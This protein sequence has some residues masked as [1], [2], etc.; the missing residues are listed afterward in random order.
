MTLVIKM[1][2]LRSLITTCTYPQYEAELT[3]KSLI[4]AHLNVLALGLWDIV[5]LLLR[6]CPALLPGVIHGG[7]ALGVLSPA[8]LLVV[9]LLK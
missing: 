4:A 8:L 5:A 2:L 6:L 9:C 1:M 3:V 7:A